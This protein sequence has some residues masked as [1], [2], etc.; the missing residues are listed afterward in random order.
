MHYHAHIYWQNE[1]QR[2]EALHLRQ[3]LQELGCQLGSIHNEPIGPHPLAMYQVNYNS[4]IAE[5]VE[6]LLSQTKLDIL[7]HEDTGDDVRD[8]TVGA[9]WI[10][11]KLKLD[12]A[13]LEDN[14]RKWHD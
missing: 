9:R 5:E 14:L 1:A 13:W 3:P 2:F 11:S 10:G 6:H 12:I 8:H 4:N 7:L